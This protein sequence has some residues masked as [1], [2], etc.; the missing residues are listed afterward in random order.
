MD[1]NQYYQSLIQQGHSSSDAAH[2]TQQYYPNFEGTAQGMAI[3]T[4]P[5]GSIEMGGMA[6]GGF[7]V[8]AGGMAASG[9]VVGG[10]T[11][12]GGISVATIAVVS[13]LVLGGAGTGGY[14]LYDYLTE[15]EF[16]GEVY[17][18]DTGYAYIFE[19]D[20][21]SAGYPLIDG[22]CEMYQDEE[23][24]MGMEIEKSN[25]ICKWNIDTYDEYSSEDKGDYYEICVDF[26]EEDED[27][28]DVYP[29]ERGIVMKQDG[30][31]E[32]LVSDINDP[33][34]YD[35][36][37]EESYEE[38]AEDS[39]KWMEKWMDIADEIEEDDDAPSCDGNSN[40]DD[41]SGGSLDTFTFSDRDAAG[42]MS[43]SGGDALVHIQMTQ[44][45]ELSWSL[46]KVTIVVEGGMSYTCYED[47]TS[48]DCT[49]YRNPDSNSWAVSEEITIYE[50][51]YLDLCD[52]SN[53][54]CEVQ[55]TLAK[56]G[57]GGNS[58][59]VIATINAFADVN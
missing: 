3:M 34:A 15:P 31:C 29:F 56:Y 5:P 19:E 18:A 37:Y 54:G 33:P 50:G 23:L 4:P 27:C 40:D 59:K 43:D 52:G 32:I 7:G 48:S 16:Y 58:D 22:S 35:D 8:P 21:F 26:E 11:T 14:F 30:E 51:D 57:V 10:A 49:W 55:V 17:W 36:S 46:L 38:F 28:I 44:G 9:I 47:E 41:S 39:E 1:A 42:V 20:G 12:G 25:G 24:G 13:V 53:G 6:A 45:N 2:F